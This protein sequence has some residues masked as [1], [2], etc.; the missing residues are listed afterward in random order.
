[1]DPG[2][3]QLDDL[4]DLVRVAARDR[5]EECPDPF[6]RGLVDDGELLRPLDATLPPVAG[7]NGEEVRARREPLT[8]DPIGLGL[9]DLEGRV[10]REDDPHRTARVGRLDRERGHRTPPTTVSFGPEASTV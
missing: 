2:D 10:R 5:A 8:D 7:P 6:G 3:I 4:G 9:R 1:M